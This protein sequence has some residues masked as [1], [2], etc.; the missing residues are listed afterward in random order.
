MHYK[1]QKNFKMKYL[2]LILHKLIV[3][4]KII[5]YQLLYKMFQN[6]YINYHKY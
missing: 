5:L 6:N 3:K 4:I 2:L 1:Y